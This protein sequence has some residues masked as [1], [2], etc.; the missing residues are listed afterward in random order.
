M[1]RLP[2]LVDAIASH[3]RRGRP[4]IAHVARQVR[5]EGLIHSTTRGVGAAT[6][7]FADATTLLLAVIGDVSPQGAVAAV[8]KLRELEPAPADAADIA[9]REDLPQALDFLRPR[10]PFF[11]TV[12]ALITNAPRLRDWHD[13][14]IDDQSGEAVSGG[15]AAE[16][17]MERMAGKF[18]AAGLRFDPSFAR[19]FRLVCYVPGVAAEVHLGRP[20]DAI[21]DD[22]GFHEFFVPP[23]GRGTPGVTAGDCHIVVEV[24][25]DMLL[26]LHHAVNGSPRP[27]GKV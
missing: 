25:V 18:R 23:K 4:T 11:D 21:D 9:K 8:R 3:D 13:A 22:D 26:A 19:P 15:S 10:R 24:G 2:A 20:W 12:E 6:M 1:P 16:V 17:A 27:H 7:T 5:N 14:Y